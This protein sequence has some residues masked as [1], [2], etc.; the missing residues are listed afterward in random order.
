MG[1]RAETVFRM[2]R[3]FVMTFSKVKLKGV[4]PF[5]MLETHWCGAI[6]P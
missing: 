5:C 6:P 3:G 1:I 2:R 4:K